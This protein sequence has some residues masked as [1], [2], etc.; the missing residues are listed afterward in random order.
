MLPCRN[1]MSRRR[2]TGRKRDIDGNTAGRASDNTILDTR[3]YTVYFEDEELTELN[4]N[5]I[6]KPMYAQCDPDGNQ[7]VL[8]DDII[9]FRKTNPALSIEHQKIFV[10]VRAPLHRST[11]VC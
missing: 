11:V 4:S 2:A 3:D 9:D 10:K 5:V 6:A 8:L 1:E 7:Y